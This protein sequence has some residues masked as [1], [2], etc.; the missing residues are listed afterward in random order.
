MQQNSI[1]Q[2]IQ[3]FWYAPV[4]VLILLSFLLLFPILNT[5]AFLEP[6]SQSYIDAG[7]AFWSTGFY[8]RDGVTPE[9]FRTPG[10]SLLTPL[11]I[12]R[13][14]DGQFFS[15]MLFILQVGLRAGV[16]LLVLNFAK[17][18][19]ILL[20]KRGAWLAAWLIATDVPS[21]ISSLII[22]SESLSA[23]FLFIGFYCFYMWGTQRDTGPKWLVASALI[24]GYATLIRPGNL[25]VPFIL[26]AGM[27][28][29]YWLIYTVLQRK[30]FIRQ[31]AIFL[32]IANLLPALW[33]ARNYAH[34]GEI[35]LS[36]KSSELLY[37]YRAASIEAQLTNRTFTD[38]ITEYRAKE[39]AYQQENQKTIWVH[40]ERWSNNGQQMILAHPD[41]ML[42]LAVK[43]LAMNMLGTSLSKAQEIERHY[44]WPGKIFSTTLSVFILGT[45]T[46]MYASILVAI[47]RCRGDREAL[48]IIGL[49]ILITL[50][51][52]LPSS[53]IESY[54]RFRVP[55]MPF[56]CLAAGFA[57][58]R[59]ERDKAPC[60]IA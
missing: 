46:V 51:L 59:W 34:T 10:Y 9:L 7:S 44:N 58:T 15:I 42:K 14:E 33:I 35:I 26:T 4:V 5:D 20:S 41:V 56:L 57:L 21:A 16:V 6:D 52:V 31:L 49:C 25:L 19:K 50:A 36:L 1:D 12:F 32:L 60:S 23:S 37:F 30:T 22:L 55:A 13:W 47:Y 39:H 53:G 54:S 38:V 18:H 27:L 11:A 45:L 2:Q 29:A 48:Y 24:L 40:A 17:G 8:S 3:R 43:G 28:L